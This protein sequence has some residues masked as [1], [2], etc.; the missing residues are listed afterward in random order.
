MWPRIGP[1]ATYGVLYLIG[2]ILHFLISRRIAK[3][4]GL[5]RRV[6][7]A[8]SVCYLVG[9][10]LGAKLLYDLRH[11]SL[12]VMAL[13]QAEHYVRGGLWG[14]LPAYWALAVPAVLLLAQDK[15]AALDLVGLSIP[16]PRY[17]REAGLSAPRRLL[18]EAL[19]TALGHHVSRRR[20]RRTG[21]R[22]PPSDATLRSRH[23]AGYPAR[24]CSAQVTAMA[25]DEAA[26][27]SGHLRPWQGHDRLPARRYR[28]TSLSWPAVTHT[29]AL[30][31]RRRCRPSC[32]RF[33]CTSDRTPPSAGGEQSMLTISCILPVSLV[34]GM[35]DLGGQRKA[36]AGNRGLA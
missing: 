35:I 9:M 31:G 17:R 11:G 33:P 34:G 24:F 13:F 14:G 5:K 28:G 12:D 18:R 22:A 15:R 10:L 36:A 25:R 16:V 27:V 8:A 7:I 2:I 6:W 20:S 30:P 23:H 32:P 21:R 29:T 1:V 19:L 26:V 4:H 3:R